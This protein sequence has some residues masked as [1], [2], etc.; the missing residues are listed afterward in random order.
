V[1]R[2][3]DRPSPGAAGAA[4]QA[5]ERAA[6][7]VTLP[8]RLP[9][10]SVSDVPRAA[11]QASRADD[12][13]LAGGGHAGAAGQAVAEHSPRTEAAGYEP[14]AGA[15][16]Y[17]SP[18]ASAA[19]AEYTAPVAGT[20]ARN[21]RGLPGEGARPGHRAARRVG[22]LAQLPYLLVLACA[23]SGFFLAWHV[24]HAVAGGAEIVGGALLAAALARLVL[25]QQAAGLLASRPR[26]A[27]VLV[28]TVLGAGLLAIGLALPPS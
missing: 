15:A 19:G 3:T 14:A 16:G 28:F 26:A 7:V 8:M 22:R 25:P 20:H 24:P 2:A 18:A 10:R 5:A 4:E 13:H 9:G 6:G 1:T 17:R 11:R 23:A 27:D 12:G 21:P